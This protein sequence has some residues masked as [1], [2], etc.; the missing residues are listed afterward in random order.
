MRRSR[1]LVESRSRRD[2]AA[3]HVAAGEALVLRT[4]SKDYCRSRAEAH[5]RAAASCRDP[6]TRKAWLESAAAWRQAHPAPTP[7]AG[8][9][10]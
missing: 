8:A 4:I 5:E 2:K 1:R 7:Q 9:T 6:D 10:T 3:R